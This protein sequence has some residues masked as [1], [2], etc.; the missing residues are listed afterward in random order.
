MDWSNK[1]FFGF[2]AAAAV[3]SS[4]LVGC[5]GDATIANAG[6][7]IVPGNG[8]ITYQPGTSNETVA[9]SASP[10]Q[11]QVKLEDGRVVTGALP[12]GIPINTGDKIAVFE[13][14]IPIF[15][16]LTTPGSAPVKQGSDIGGVKVY[17][18]GDS[19]LHETGI[20]VKQG[21]LSGRIICPDGHFRV[22]LQ[23]PF[24]IV[25]GG[26]RLDIQEFA[27]EIWVRNGKASIPTRV[28]GEL[29]VNG[30]SS[31]PLQLG[32][33]I[34]TV[35]AGGKAALTIVHANGTLSKQL[36]LDSNAH[37]TFHDFTFQGNS[38]IPRTGVDLVEFKYTD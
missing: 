19:T 38:Q 32:V 15:E 4:V 26:N 18:V 12:S 17:M 31:F 34:P 35:Y 11:V 24:A 20:K 37:V 3:A 16:G 7:P 10:Q 25:G 5:A 6:T 29:P 22:V 33:D 28:R 13:P 21:G 2:L 30:G 14:D 1:R 27:F 23:G 9:A 36:T 8:G